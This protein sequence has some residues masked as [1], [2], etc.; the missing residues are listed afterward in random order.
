MHNQL[1][2]LEPGPGKGGALVETSLEGAMVAKQIQRL[3][4]FKKIPPESMPSQTLGSGWGE[5]DREG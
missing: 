3:P 4:D 2:A 1:W 5:T